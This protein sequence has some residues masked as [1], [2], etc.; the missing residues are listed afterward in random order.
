MVRV[1]RSDP[2]TYSKEKHLHA[3]RQGRIPYAG[4]DRPRRGPSPTTSGSS[5]LS[6][7]D[8]Q[9][10]A[11]N[12]AAVQ[13]MREG[14]HPLG[15]PRHGSGSA[16][17]LPVQR[18]LSDT[19]E[20]HTGHASESV[21]DLPEHIVELIRTAR[22]SDR[23]TVLQ[24]LFDHILDRMP[25]PTD[26]AG[27]E[28]RANLLRNA[29]IRYVHTYAAPGRPQA[30]TQEAP[31]GPQDTPGEQT[32]TMSFHRNL[33]DLGPA[34]VYNTM[35]HELIHAAQRSLAPDEDRA[36]RSD[37]HIFND[38]M[39]DVVTAGPTLRTLQLPMQEIEAH[40]W[41]LRNIG[42]TGIDD[43]Q[44]RSTVHYLVEYTNKLRGCLTWCLLTW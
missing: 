5:L 16:E 1:C 44:I 36:H 29:K 41:E 31:L 27:E 9:N 39:A 38:P 10:T 7:T 32:V 37:A 23:E 25:V 6:V 8:I 34:H 14:H 11:G 42:R 13:I 43:G 24:I 21:P 35:R 12:K 28:G 26:E 19:L 33:F 20:P 15:R 30:L 2:Y 18:V 17:G 4:A 22:P 3:P 40:V